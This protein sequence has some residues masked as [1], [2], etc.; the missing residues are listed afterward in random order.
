MASSSQVIEMNKPASP[1]PAAP[2]FV[3]PPMTAPTA[4][5]PP[6]AKRAKKNGVKKDSDGDEGEP[7]PLPVE[8]EAMEYFDADIAALIHELWDVLPDTY[9]KWDDQ[10]DSYACDGAYARFYS[11]LNASAANAFGDL[12]VE[13]SRS[14]TSRDH[15]RLFA[16]GGRSMQSLQGEIRHMIS[17]G[18]YYDIDMKNAHPVLLVQYAARV[19]R[20]VAAGITH[21]IEHR[22][23]CFADI[24]AAYGMTK[25]QAKKALLSLVNGGIF[26]TYFDVAVPQ[27]EWLKNFRGDV[28]TI[29]GEI[30]KLSQSDPTLKKWRALI[31][32]NKDFNVHGSLLNHVLCELEHTALMASHSFAV[33]RG[34]CAHK[35]GDIVLCFDGLQLPRAAFERR[36]I[37]LDAFMKDMAAHVKEKTGYAVEFASKPMDGGMTKRELLQLKLR[38]PKEFRLPPLFMLSGSPSPVRVARLMHRALPGRYVFCNNEWYV[39]EDGKWIMMSTEMDRD[40]YALHRAIAAKTAMN[41]SAFTKDRMGDWL[42]QMTQPDPIRKTKDAARAMYSKKPE[43]FIELL[44]LNPALFGV[45]NGVIDLTTGELRPCEPEDL[46]SKCA[47]IAYPDHDDI[48]IQDKLRAFFTDIMGVG[49]EREFLMRSCAYAMYGAQL[50]QDLNFTFWVGKGGNGKSI[51]AKLL[52]TAFGQYMES[53]ANNFLADHKSTPSGQTSHLASL[54]GVRLAMV[55]EPDKTKNIDVSLPKQLTTGDKLVVREMYGKPFS[56]TPILKLIAFMNNPPGLS[57]IDGGFKRRLTVLPF[58]FLFVQNPTLPNERLVDVTL[59]KYVQR[60]DV[61]GQFLRMMV[62]ILIDDDI[63]A[64]GFPIPESVKVESKR[65]ITSKDVVGSFIDAKFDITGSVD[66][67]VLYSEFKLEFVEF[68]SEDGPCYMKQEEMKH[69]ALLHNSGIT[70]NPKDTRPIPTSDNKTT[71]R[72]TA[73]LCGLRRKVDEEVTADV[74][75]Q[76]AA[77]MF[78]SFVPAPPAPAATPATPKMNMEKYLDRN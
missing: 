25:V 65:Y 31:E 61:A 46:V 19:L 16:L 5:T 70:F 6:A 11:F 37:D 54:R 43:D 76:P 3:T 2:L 22:E 40:L 56:F 71:K 9:T 53:T 36:G 57:D 26:G 62:K 41:I 15:G 14:K 44:D 17:A 73:T 51:L 39:C 27:P 50:H 13:Y 75:E 34:L 55:P 64:K 7:E 23:E 69:R 10:P 59:T 18:R 32:E 77:P 68:A 66:D 8:F 47:K 12:P 78:V 24:M 52:E 35:G 49:G 63:V 20:F 29:T 74:E 45:K 28:T 1:S 67:A 38:T 72:N 48:E 58:P 4:P 21:Y 60:A 42:D 30:A 33:S